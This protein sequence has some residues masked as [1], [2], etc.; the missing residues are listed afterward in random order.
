MRAYKQKCI[1]LQKELKLANEINAVYRDILL[2]MQNQLNK[3]T[4]AL[5][6]IRKMEV[7]QR[8]E[9][10]AKD[11]SV[12]YAPS[13]IESVAAQVIFEINSELANVSETIK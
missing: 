11:L 5:E 4:N 6:I 12:I 2:I 8:T 7:K 9:Q 10:Q 1:D 13:I 3:A